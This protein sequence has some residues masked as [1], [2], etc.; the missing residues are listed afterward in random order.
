MGWFQKGQKDVQQGKQ[1]HTPHNIGSAQK[2][3]YQK[4]VAAQKAADDRR[5][6]I[7]KK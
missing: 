6:Q 1:P 4:G 2:E 3:Q 7:D 5:K